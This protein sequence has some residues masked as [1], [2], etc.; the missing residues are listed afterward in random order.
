M[1]KQIIWNFY[2]RSG[3][4]TGRTSLI[5]NFTTFSVL[6]LCPL[7]T[8][9]GS[10]GIIVWLTHSSIL[11]ES[12]NILSVKAY[13]SNFHIKTIININCFSEIFKEQQLKTGTTDTASFT[14]NEVSLLISDVTYTVSC[15]SKFVSNGCYKY[16]KPCLFYIQ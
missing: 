12:F 3:I 6:E 13:F 15:L 10:G 5:S 1:L 14:L 8:V 2:T 16:C 7:F 9:V 4:I 11:L